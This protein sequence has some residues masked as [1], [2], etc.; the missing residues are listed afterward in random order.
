MKVYRA[1]R[2][3]YDYYEWEETLGI[4]VSKKVLMDE[5]QLKQYYWFDELKGMSSWYVVDEQEHKILAEMEKS[6]TMIVEHELI[7]A[8]DE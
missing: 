5:Y 6:H 3:T 1:V 4:G 8:V 2:Y 7:G